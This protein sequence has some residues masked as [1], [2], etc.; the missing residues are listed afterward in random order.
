[1]ISTEWPDGAPRP[2]RDQSNRPPVPTPLRPFR[3]PREPLPPTRIARSVRKS[4]AHLRLC[5]QHPCTTPH[6][7]CADD[8]TC[9]N[10]RMIINTQQSN[11]P[12]STRLPRACGRGADE[13]SGGG[14]LS[15]PIHARPYPPTNLAP[16]I[17]N[18]S[19]S[20]RSIQDC[21]PFATIPVYLT[22]SELSLTGRKP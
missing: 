15:P 22:G 1:M 9:D 6:Q 8:E 18:P 10:S 2:L 4:I 5:A 7:A 11:K 3:L 14:L 12:D 19:P 17:P 21:I 20:T 16:I 13:V